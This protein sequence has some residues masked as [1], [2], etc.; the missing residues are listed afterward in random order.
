[1]YTEVMQI[2]DVAAGDL[3]EVLRLNED[4]VPHVSSVDL[5]GMEWFA[6]NAHYFR[7]V[8]RQRQL[9]GFLIGLRPGLA[10][11]SPNYGWFSRNYHDF[12]YIDRV[13]VSPRARRLGIASRLYQ[14]FAAT[15]RGDIDIMTCEVNIRPPNESSMRFHERHGFVRVATQET[16]GG[17]KEVAL[18]EMNL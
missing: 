13:A 1:M 5:A 6:A 11:D 18:L 10:Y 4:S 14:D 7:V 16:E 8:R 2:S 9:A 3:E 12:G 17:K 15:L